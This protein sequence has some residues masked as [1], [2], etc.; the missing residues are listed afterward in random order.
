MEKAVRSVG[1]PAGKTETGIPKE[2]VREYKKFL[3]G[4][5]GKITKRQFAKSLGMGLSTFHKYEN[6]IRSISGQEKKELKVLA[7]DFGLLHRGDVQ[8]IIE[9]CRSYEEGQKQIMSVYTAVYMR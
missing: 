6:R 5:Y 2:F 8:E 9:T 1:R 7:D 4:K 3:A